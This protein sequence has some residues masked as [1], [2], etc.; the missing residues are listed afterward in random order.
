MKKLIVGGIFIILMII[1]SA[2][3]FSWTPNRIIWAIIISV[4]I[5]FSFF[6][7]DAPKIAGSIVLSILF[8]GLGMIVLAWIFKFPLPYIKLQVEDITVMVIF[9]I[10]LAIATIANVFIYYKSFS[11]SRLSH[12]DI[13][14]QKNL[15]IEIKNSGEFPAR[16]IFVEMELFDKNK[17]KGWE[18]VKSN[19]KDNLMVSEK[20]ISYLAR[21][22]RKMADFREKIKKRFDVSEIADNIYRTN[23]PKSKTKFDIEVKVTYYSD[24]LSKNPYPIFKRVKIEISGKDYRFER[25]D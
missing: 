22:E 2:L 10:V 20:R 7:E 6:E 15:A 1:L 4:I 13:S 14:I 25:I 5:L 3:N 8:L 16:N 18:K 19:F 17:L 12:L 21:G 11:I 23:S 9:T 24:L